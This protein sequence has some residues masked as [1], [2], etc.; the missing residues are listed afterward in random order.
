MMLNPLTQCRDSRIELV[1]DICVKKED[2]CGKKRPYI[3]N[4]YKISDGSKVYYFVG[5]IPYVL[6][7]ISMLHAK[8]SIVEVDLSFEV[9]R[10]LWT[11]QSVL[12]HRKHEDCKDTFHV[13]KFE[14]AFLVDTVLAQIKKDVSGIRGQNAK[15]A[16]T[17]Q[18]ELINSHEGQTYE[19]DAAIV[20]DDEVTADRE[21][22]QN[23]S[24]ALSKRKLK[25]SFG[26]P[27]K[28]KLDF[29]ERSR[30]KIIVLSKESCLRPMCI[31]ALSSSIEM[32]KIGVIPVLNGLMA[33]EIPEFMSWMSCISTN[34]NYI[35]SLLNIMM[36]QELQMDHCLPRGNVY[37]GF[38][39]GY[40]LNYLP[41]P[42]L[43]KAP[44]SNIQPVGPD[45]TSRIKTTLRDKKIMCGCI[46]K[47]YLCIPKSCEDRKLDEADGVA[48]IGE[49]E[50][51]KIGV[52]PYQLAMY[53]IKSPDLPSGQVCFLAE[54][55]A[56]TKHLFDISK[57]YRDVGISAKDLHNQSEEFCKS[58]AA[59]IRNKVFIH[60]VGDLN[61][62]CQFLFYDDE[63]Y[64]KADAL[65][66]LKNVLKD[67]IMDDLAKN[68]EVV[69]Q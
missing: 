42:L 66:I 15:C 12:T 13:I 51:V 34:E 60:D 55:P 31:F 29:L 14:A 41:I 5:E 37:T 32:N 3:V 10:F 20:F 53:R 47:L 48:K 8:G 4:L 33:K 6:N 25:V 57:Q 7:T 62:L 2:Y 17:P 28:R 27:G 43:G 16:L 63:T 45:L 1:A 19:L 40:I 39:W 38:V 30:W 21:I 9:D 50:A 18:A 23:I 56:P 58:C 69:Y 46:R 64:N 35:D 52:R 49:L 11:L 68:I 44:G 22:A 24:N 67:A 61:S 65:I 54:Q 59:N 26:Q 36:G